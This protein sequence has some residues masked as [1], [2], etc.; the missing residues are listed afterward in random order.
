M[1]K[2][3]RLVAQGTSGRWIL[4]VLAGWAFFIFA[5]CLSY[6]MLKQR[7]EFK[8]ETLVSMFSSLLL[9]IQ[10]V[11][12]EYFSKNGDSNGPDKEKEI[13][14]EENGNS[15]PQGPQGVEK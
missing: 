15:G 7:A 8:P 11:F 12:K 13:E 9:I 5:A 10:G 1:R 14:T 4:T 3:E 2:M 6:V